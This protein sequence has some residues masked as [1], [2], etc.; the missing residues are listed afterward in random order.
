MSA[1]ERHA[2]HGA[3]DEGGNAASLSRLYSSYGKN[4]R[5]PANAACSKTITPAVKCVQSDAESSYHDQS[6]HHR[7]EKMKG[8]VRQGSGGKT[9]SQSAIEAERERE[10]VSYWE[11][12]A[13]TP[14]QGRNKAERNG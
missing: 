12:I 8:N 5:V 11:G 2:G 13:K 1:E 3:H 7:E 14:T 10:R 9:Q 4:W 6:I